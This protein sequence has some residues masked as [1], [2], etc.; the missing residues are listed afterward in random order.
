M[1]IILVGD[2][3]GMKSCWDM[4]NTVPVTLDEML[5]HTRAVRRGTKHALLGADYCRSV[6][7]LSH[8]GG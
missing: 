6:R 4:K 7:Q 2:S 3:L 1:D 8:W 5:H